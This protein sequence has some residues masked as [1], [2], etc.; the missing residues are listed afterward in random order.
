MKIV[1]KIFFWIILFF[2]TGL[3]FGF[4]IDFQVDKTE[5]DLLDKINLNIKVTWTGSMD[6]IEISWIDGFSVVWKSQS[7]AVSII[8]NITETSVEMRVQ[9]MPTLVWEYELWPVALVSWVE[10]IKW[11]KTFKIKVTDSK[12]SWSFN[13]FQNNTGSLIDEDNDNKIV[14]YDVDKESE[15]VQEK[16][17]NNNTNV[18]TWSIKDINDIDWVKSRFWKISFIFII[19]ALFF[20]VF[21]FVLKYIL[22]QKGENK[23]EETIIVEEKIDMK[24]MFKSKLNRLKNKSNDLDKTE[25]YAVLNMLFREFFE[26]LWEKKATKKTFKELENTGLNDKKIFDL[27]R[28]SYFNEFNNSE[29]NND[30]RV[31]I[32]DKF[33]AMI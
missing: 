6:Q 9:L 2:V 17:N 3:A 24:D 21:Y 12:K 5:V 31:D 19:V 18:W 32:I 15:N 27:F 4:D 10:K 26:Y 20:I 25:F 22:S 28:R 11:D 23:K 30:S 33:I 16:L 13:S 29:D 1:L 8:N 14:I 7:R